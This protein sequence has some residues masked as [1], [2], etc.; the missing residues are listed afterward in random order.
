M[1]KIKTKFGTAT[2][3]KYGYYVIVSKKEGN[4]SKY[5]HVLVW[6]DFYKTKKPEGYVIHHKNYNKSDFCILNLQLMRDAEHRALHNKT[7]EIYSDTRQKMSDNQ[8]LKNGGQHPK[9]MK[10]KHHSKETKQKMSNS[11]TKKY[12]RII[13]GGKNKQGRQK[14]TLVYEGKILKYSINPK[15]LMDSFLKNYPLEIIKIPDILK[16]TGA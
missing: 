1:S 10:G 9:G 3:N 6:E 11:L 4:F 16:K 8:W 5:L 2:L 15:K 12:A 13:K 14:Y 7:R